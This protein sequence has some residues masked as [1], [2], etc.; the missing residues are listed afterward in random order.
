[1][2]PFQKTGTRARRLAADEL[3]DPRLVL[4]RFFDYAGIDQQREQLWEWLKTMVSGSY[5][6]RLLTKKQR[7]DLLYFYE[8]LQRLIE[9]AH[10]L[11]EQQAAGAKRKKKRPANL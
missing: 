2:S 5:S 9:A 6:S 10:L 8:Q 7:Y 3:K 4:A 1:M 11:H